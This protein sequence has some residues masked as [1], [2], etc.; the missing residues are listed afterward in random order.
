[1]KLLN[2]FLLINI[3]MKRQNH[4]Q[5]IKAFLLL[6]ICLL[7]ISIVSSFRFND[8]TDL[9]QSIGL[10]VGNAYGQAIDYESREDGTRISFT[11]PDARFEYKGF[12]YK[13]VKPLDDASY[14]DLNNEGEMI[15][16][17]LTSN[18]VG[19]G[20]SFGNVNAYVPPDARL[21]FN[22]EGFYTGE[23]ININVPSGGE[24]LEFPRSLGLD[25]PSYLTTIEGNDL[26]LPGNNFMRGR[27]NFFE[28]RTF[29]VLKDRTY[30]NGAGLTNDIND[31]I[32]TELEE[33]NVIFEGDVTENSVSF[34]D[35]RLVVSAP[36][37]KDGAVVNLEE[38]NPYVEVEEGDSLVI[39]PSKGSKIEIE[40]RDD[41]EMIPKVTTNGDATIV[42][43][44]GEIEID[45]GNVY[46]KKPS[47]PSQKEEFPSSKVELD[48]RDKD[49][50][51]NMQE[52]IVYTDSSGRAVVYR[53]SKDVNLTKEQ[54]ENLV[55]RVQVSKDINL[56][57]EEIESL[58]LRMSY[59]REEP[60]FLNRLWDKFQRLAGEVI[61]EEKRETI[62][63]VVGVKG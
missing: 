54:I 24:L 31:E 35:N 51:S 39:Q 13:N 21:T 61:G 38:D 53:V 15:S 41:E 58:V 62:T 4:P 32:R 55:S 11:H 29:S 8:Y 27:L 37:D 1:M 7:I 44:D 50:N 36:N 40:N 46:L 6:T 56:T 34:N 63:T 22:V 14:I 60:S 59:N 18:E 42:N 25:L 47:V 52:Y 26:I 12:E 9:S 5:F 33:T 23:H 28:T 30:I 45:E 57:G 20:Y 16:A 19:G 49:G 48:L 10:P 17:D 3:K 43:G 2:L